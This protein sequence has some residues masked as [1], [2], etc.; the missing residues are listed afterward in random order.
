SDPVL[1]N[2]HAYLDAATLFNRGLPNDQ[3][4]PVQVTAAEAGLVRWKCDVHPWM[5]GYVG[6]SRNGLQ[7]VTGGD[8]AFRIANVPPGKYALEAWHER[9]GTQSQPL[10][11]EA[12]KSARLT[13]T[14][15]A[16]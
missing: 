9:L 1:H 13:F 6:V 5:R 16:K 4:P 10:A 3:A 11:V 7:A 8:G 14:F 12:G 15:A 2:V